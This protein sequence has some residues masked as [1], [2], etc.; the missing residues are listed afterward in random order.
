MLNWFK[1]EKPFSGFGGFGGGLGSLGATT[2][3]RTPVAG[4]YMLLGAGGSGGAHNAGGGGGGGGGF[5]ENT[6]TEL[7]TDTY[8]INVG[9]GSAGTSGGPSYIQGAYYGVIRRVEGGGAGGGYGFGANGGAGGGAGNNNTS[10]GVAGQEGYGLK[11]GTPAP[12]LNSFPHYTPGETQGYPGGQ[13]PGTVNTLAG[14]GGGAGGVG[15][16]ANG[17]GGNG[18]YSPL[19]GTTVGGGGG[20]AGYPGGPYSSG[21]PGGGGNAS[22]S[23]AQ[24]GTD[25]LGGGGGAAPG[26]SGGRG[27]G[28]HGRVIWRVLTSNNAGITHTNAT[29]STSGSYTIYTWTSNGTL[30]IP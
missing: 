22:S 18:I 20:A 2:V 9:Q 30:T 3:V 5:H 21:G 17:N 16:P 6:S 24:Q 12:V 25:S 10:P 14:G 8:T 23:S 29:V 7:L 26:P 13:N 11:P 15:G 1:K 28:G 4:A 27:R 19:A